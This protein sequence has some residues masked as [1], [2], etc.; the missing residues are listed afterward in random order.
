MRTPERAVIIICYNPTKEKIIN[1]IAKVKSEG[2]NIYI[3]NNGG[4]SDN[5]IDSLQEQD[6][7]VISFGANLGLGK[8]INKIAENLPNTVQAIFTFDQDS[9]PPDN[10]ILKV[11]GKYL[12]LME[13]KIPLGVL[14]PKFVD[15]RSGYQYQQDAIATDDEFTELTITLQSGMCIPLAVWCREK[16]NPELFIEFVDTEWCYRIKSKG[17]KVLQMNDIVMHHEVSDQAPKT[18][19]S[20][21]LLKY[22]PIRRYYFFRNAVFLLKQDYVPIYNK[23][24]LLTGACNRILSIALLDELKFE[25]YKQSIRGIVDGIKLRKK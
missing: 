2:T 13:R 21:K 14:T 9:A 22:K 25:A 3:A 17:Y 15:A 18:F 8:A 12:K 1:L 10:Y 20:F 11:W 19:L 6:V 7:N 5:L 23:F 16:F 24:R 4:M